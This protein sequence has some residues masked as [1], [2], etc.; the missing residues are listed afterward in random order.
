MLIKARFWGKIPVNYS[1]ETVET[2]G[3][4][5]SSGSV[6]GKSF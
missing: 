6:D 1:D 4:I 5:W 2:T 3:L